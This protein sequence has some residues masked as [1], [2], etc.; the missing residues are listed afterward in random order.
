MEN[1]AGN[2]TANVAGSISGS[3]GIIRVDP[4]AI[5]NAHASAGIEPPAVGSRAGYGPNGRKLNKDG[6]ER[7]AK[8]SGGNAAAPRT[9]APPLSVD[10]LTFA[11][12]GI[13]T[14]LATTLKV[15]ELALDPREGQQLALALQNLQRFYNIQMTEKALAWS[16][17]T[18][19][20]AT[21]YATRAAA[22]AAR[23]KMEARNPR[24]DNVIRPQQFRPAVVTP[25]PMTPPQAAPLTP[26]GDPV[27]AAPPVNEAPKSAGDALFAS[28]DPAYI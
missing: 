26:D 10:T 27:S 3:D 23:M 6:T 24:Q 18:M 16:N 2:G 28:I 8:G 15:P 7:K 22:I 4:A 5:D 19:T 9:Q 14:L 21:I 1:G 11:I 12:V 20:C 17:L 25:A 13:H